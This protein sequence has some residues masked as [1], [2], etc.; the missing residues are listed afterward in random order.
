MIERENDMEIV[1][2]TVDPFDLLVAVKEKHANAVILSVG[3]AETSGLCSH[4][5]AEYP[6]LTVLELSFE[7]GRAFLEQLCPSR[8]E[9]A[10]PSA[11]SVLSALRQ[12]IRE[13]CGWID[14]SDNGR[15]DP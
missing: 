9:I 5:L 6:T 14:Q 1:G 3:E 8:R 12:A 7:D 13:P 4:L 11:A 2:E 15:R 10:D